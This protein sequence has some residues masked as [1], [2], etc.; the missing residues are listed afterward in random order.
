MSA[1]D[2]RRR[3]IAP[4]TFSLPLFF[5]KI[6]TRSRSADETRVF[7]DVLFFDRN[8]IE[9]MREHAVRSFTGAI[10]A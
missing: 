1:R 2:E 4:K 9:R 7:S 10:N 3:D 5:V 6:S 8:A